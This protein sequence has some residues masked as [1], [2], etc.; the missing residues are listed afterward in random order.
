[1]TVLPGSQDPSDP[2]IIILGYAQSGAASVL[3]LLEATSALACTIGSGIVP[4]CQ[5]AAQTWRNVD[6]RDS[7][8]SALATS[9][10]RHLT[11]IMIIT[12][13]VRQGRSRWCETVFSPAA[14]AE[15]FAQIYPAAQF[16]CLHR[17]SLATIA[18]AVRTNPW[19]LAGTPF[20]EFAPVHPASPAATVAAYWAAATERLLQ[21][22][23]A[24]PGKCLRV[25]HEDL[26]S[27]PIHT[28]AAVYAFLNLSPPSQIPP[29][30]LGHARTG[31]TDSSQG[32][33]DPS[34][35]DQIPAPLQARINTLHDRLGL[36]AA[37]LVRNSRSTAQSDADR[38]PRLEQEQAR[39][40]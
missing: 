28:A 9:S 18:A 37:F 29:A 7:P 13:L 12:I 1:V 16:L 31:P 26:T 39:E 36:P 21:F 27:K 35:L 30:D 34:L 10:I 22:E 6:D 3:R 11:D 15:T 33:C 32:D 8:L 14:S 20:A 40:I 2:P 25:R 17:S 4:L 24:N 38:L 5:Q 19:G 23:E